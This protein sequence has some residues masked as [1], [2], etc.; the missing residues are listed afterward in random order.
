ME[1]RRQVDI[2]FKY[3]RKYVPGFENAVLIESGAEIGIRET[4]H[5]VGRYCVT[6]NDVMMGSCFE[7]CIAL[8]GFPMD[9]HD[10][11][12]RNDQFIAPKHANCYQVPY[13]A[14]IPMKTENLLIAGRSISA[15]SGAA[16]A[17][18][19]MPTCFAM[20]EAAG[21]AA[22]LAFERGGAISVSA[23]DHVRLRELLRSVGACVDAGE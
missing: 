2:A 20:G 10:N 14:L 23:V 16:A 15:T 1:G 12:G 21:I 9:I 17:L 8:S 7:D 18:R 5:I 3:L 11:S 4:R 6:E 22:S 13:R 19:V